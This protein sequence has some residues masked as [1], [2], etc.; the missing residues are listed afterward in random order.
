MTDE[1]KPCPFCGGHAETVET[2]RHPKL[3]ATWC[4]TCHV[5]TGK[6]TAKAD[7]IVAW[8]RRTTQPAP[9]PVQAGEVLPIEEERKHAEHE[10]T[11]TAFDYERNPVG[12]RE[13][14]LY[15]AGW[16]ARST[17]HRRAAIKAGG[18]G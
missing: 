6:R 10:Y 18:Q 11:V 2:D 13:W 15:W 8:N 9:I 5:S 4:P 3:Y 1:L 7:C 17:L 12:A 16:L 14:T